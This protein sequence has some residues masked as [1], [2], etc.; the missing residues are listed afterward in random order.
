M[1]FHKYRLVIVGIPKNASRSL[2]YLLTN[3]SD[4]DI[5]HFTYTEIRD[6]HDKELLDSYHSLAVVRNPYDR[7]ISAYLYTL[8]FSDFFIRYPKLN[9][10]NRYLK[11]IYHRNLEELNDDPIRYPQWKFI[12]DGENILVDTVLRFESLSSD[13]EKFTVSYN[14]KKSNIFKIPKSIH[15]LN[16]NTEKDKDY[17]SYYD[18]T[19]IKMVNEMYKKDFEMFNYKML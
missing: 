9:N 8:Y 16:K 13:W 15:E 18:K 2:Y 7:A 19:S 10:F 11:A 1:V 4:Q 3:K 5:N 12:T 17:M 6:H 14:S